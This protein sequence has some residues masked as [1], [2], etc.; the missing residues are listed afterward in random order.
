MTIG[1]TTMKIYKWVPIA[2]NEPK[3]KH[4]DSNKENVSRK[5]THDSSNTSFS[6]VEDSNTC[7]KSS[8]FILHG[9]V[10]D[11]AFRLFDCQRFA[12]SD[13][14]LVAHDI[15]GGLQ[16]AEQRA[17]HQEAEIG[18]KGSSKKARLRFTVLFL[19]H[20]SFL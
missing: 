3:K 9:N 2:T 13:R 19:Y 8:R 10:R 15:L 11:F 4:K 20:F 12:G 6:I 18:V 14:F 7:K 5:S 16:L 1:D 17:A